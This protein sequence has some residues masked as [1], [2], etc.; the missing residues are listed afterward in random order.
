MTGCLALPVPYRSEDPF[1]DKNISFIIPEITNKNTVKEKLG[2]PQAYRFGEKI[3][4]Y[5]GGQQDWVWLWVVG[6]GYSATGGAIPTYMNHL[7]IV[8]FNE[9]DV[10][11]AVQEFCGDTGKLESG[12]YIVSNGGHGKGLTA[13]K[14]SFQDERLIILASET[15]D[16]QAKQF[17][18]S[19]EKATVFYY[20]K[21]SHN[22][23]AKLDNQVSVDPGS[24]GY[25]LWIVDP[26]DHTISASH[27]HHPENLTIRCDPG[28]TYYVEHREGLLREE[29]KTIGEKEIA[30]RRLVCDRIDPFNFNKNIQNN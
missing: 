19:L 11:T 27:G 26:G 10:V 4:I 5:A 18:V 14:W 17:F 15:M 25:L 24:D 29:H 2:T 28:T 16:K 30:K 13:K 20:K 9:D 7:L 6:G 21:F 1:P 8:E 22:L 12:L 23:E 3:Y